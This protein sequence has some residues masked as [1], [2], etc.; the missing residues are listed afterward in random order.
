MKTDTPCKVMCLAKYTK[1]QAKIIAD[2]I[3][4]DYNVHL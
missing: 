2:R 4:E 1:D 3:K